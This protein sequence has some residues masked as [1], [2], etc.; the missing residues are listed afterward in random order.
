MQP[1]SAQDELSTSAE[2]EER[3]WEVAGIVCSPFSETSGSCL[4]ITQPVCRRAGPNRGSLTSMHLDLD[5]TTWAAAESGVTGTGFN[6][7]LSGM[8]L[9]FLNKRKQKVV[10]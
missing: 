5:F 9:T 1:L 8:G 10:V 6:I 4:E 2:T 7:L 3:P